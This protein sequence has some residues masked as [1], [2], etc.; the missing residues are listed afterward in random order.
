[1]NDLGNEVTG[2]GKL[3]SCSLR[4]CEREAVGLQRE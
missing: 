3:L 1:V 4:Y 2:R